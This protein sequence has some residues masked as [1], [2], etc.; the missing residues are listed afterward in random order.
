[1]SQKTPHPQ[2]NRS[3]SVELLMCATQFIRRGVRDTNSNEIKKNQNEN[4]GNAIPMDA[5]GTQFKNFKKTQNF[6]N[7]KIGAIKIG[8]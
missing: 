2:N 7:S 3:K 1:M 4:S 6:E 5:K 8:A